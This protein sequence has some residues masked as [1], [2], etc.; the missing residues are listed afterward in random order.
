ML[1]HVTD[2]MNV[3]VGVFSGEELGAS[4]LRGSEAELHCAPGRD[5]LLRHGLGHSAAV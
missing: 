1:T 2:M 5:A 4:R 3:C